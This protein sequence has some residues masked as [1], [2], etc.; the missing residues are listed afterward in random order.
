MKCRSCGASFDDEELYFCTVCGAMLK[1]PITKEMVPDN[2]DD[3]ENPK[4]V[5]TENGGP[6]IIE[7][8]EQEAVPVPKEEASPEEEKAAEPVLPV[9]EKL[10]IEEEKPPVEEALPVAE[11]PPV[12]EKLPIREAPPVNEDTA[13]PVKNEELYIARERE[14][15]REN[16][17]QPEPPVI[18]PPVQPAP[19]DDTQ[20]KFAENPPP[21]PKKV[22]AGRI[23]GASVI[24]IFAGIV[25]V[26]VSLLFSLKL[27]LSPDRMSK[28]VK[29]TDVWKIINA[30]VD[31]MTVSDAVYYE[32]NFD[33]ATHGF[34]DKSEFAFYLS[35]TDVTGFLSEKVKIY[36]DYILNGKGDEPTVTENEI[37][38]YF[39][40][41]GE[42]GK[43]VFSYDMQTADY[44]SIR[45]SLTDR[46]TSERFSVSGIGWNIKFR[47]ENV[48]H[49]LS[50]PTLSILAVL[51]LVLLIWIAVVVNHKG[52][53]TLGLYGNILR[54]GGIATIAAGFIASPAMALMYVLDEKFH[55]LCLSLLLFPPAV[56]A[57]IIGAI[58]TVAGVILLKA[59]R[60]IKVKERIN[61]GK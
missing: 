26:A 30:E 39:M 49:L 6:D 34:A 11:N 5:P 25:L 59:K 9:T 7:R 31:G 16:I 1:N 35:K 46:K 17:S 41:Y 28:S 48:K 14:R 18:P 15:E 32:T 56:Y 33:K 47:L 12:E 50:Y 21:K 2:D 29:N 61:R 36:A 24:S 53:H 37:T 45:S 58:L 57:V 52:K 27:G 20:P 13:P 19:F 3:A 51:F 60:A 38:E 23:M 22:G 44:N 54:W 43:E 8:P 10:P 55:Y 4:P 42:T 40:E